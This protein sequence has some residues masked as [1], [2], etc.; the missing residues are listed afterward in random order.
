MWCQASLTLPTAHAAQ[1]TEDVGERVFNHL[2]VTAVRCLS[3][4]QRIPRRAPNGQAR[5]T[6]MISS[7]Q[8]P[9]ADPAEQ[10]RIIA[11][12]VRIHE[13]AVLNHESAPSVEEEEDLFVATRRLQ[14]P[15]L[16]ATPSLD[17]EQGSRDSILQWWK[18]DALVAEKSDEDS[19]SEHDS[20][21]S[22]DWI[23]SEKV[24]SWKMKIKWAKNSL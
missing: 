10:P 11:A 22:L 12:A 13:S 1:Q 5:N 18:S 16:V 14:D 15:L 7:V 17:Q 23:L 8:A 6:G 21:E 20:L 2:R 3:M 19:Q 9:N 24:S 4:L